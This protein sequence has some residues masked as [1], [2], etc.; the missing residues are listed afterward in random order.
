MAVG[1]LPSVKLSTKYLRYPSTLVSYARMAFLIID[2]PVDASLPQYISELKKY[3]AEHV[4]RACEPTYHPGPL[5]EAGIQIHDLPFEDGEPPPKRVIEDWLALVD[6]VFEVGKPSKGKKGKKGQ[7][8]PDGPGPEGCIA[9]HC[10]AGLG[11]APALVAIA[12]MERG[13][14]EPLDAIMYIRERRKGA[15]NAK[16]MAYL[17]VYNARGAKST[18]CCVV[19]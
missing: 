9:V 1:P 15:F 5:L 3:N 13:G 2:A 19:Q 7:E 8:P 18:A 12:L 16:Q 17:E 4:V 14:M 6:A 10:Q 11:R